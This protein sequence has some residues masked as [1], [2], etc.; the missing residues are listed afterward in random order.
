MSGA[1]IDCPACG[2]EH[3][4]HSDYYESGTRFEFEC[5]CGATFDVE[6]EF[7]PVFYID[8]TTVKPKKEPAE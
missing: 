3:E 5:D 4:V 2:Q 8:G 6:V 7:L 1:D